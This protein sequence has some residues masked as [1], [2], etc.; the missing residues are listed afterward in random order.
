MIVHGYVLS[1]DIHGIVL[2]KGKP[3][4]GV[5]V[6]VAN[7]KDKFVVSDSLGCFFISDVQKEDSIVFSFVGFHDLRIPVC[8]LYNNNNQVIMTENSMNLNE[9]IVFRNKEISSDFSMKS[10]NQLE[11][12]ASPTSQADPLNAVLSTA[13]ST[14][15]LESAKPSLRGSSMGYTMV[16]INGVPV[17][18]P[19][20]GNLVNSS[21]ASSSSINATFVGSES[22]YASN[23]PIE[24]ENAASGSVNIQLN[25]DVKDRKNF[26]LSS[27]GTSF[28]VNRNFG[29]SFLESYLSYTDLYPFIKMNNTKDINH[30]RSYDAGIHY[31]KTLKKSAYSI[32][33]SYIY[34]NGNYPT[35]YLD[36]KTDYF[37]KSSFLN[38]IVNYEYYHAGVKLK[39]DFSYSHLKTNIKYKNIHM[40]EY[41]NYLYGAVSYSQFV[42]E[43]LQFKSGI[44]SIFSNFNTISYYSENRSD[45]EKGNMMQFTPYAS[46]KLILGNYSVLLGT[47]YSLAKDNKPAFNTNIS[48][49]YTNTHHKILLSAANLDMYNY[50]EN[51]LLRYSKMSCKQFCIEYDY[52]KSGLNGHFALYFK[53]ENGVNRM[54]PMVGDYKK[55]VFGIETSFEIQLLKN[56]SWSV[57]NTYLNT[58]YSFL[59]TIR[60]KGIRL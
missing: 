50:Y 33:S 1:S 44:N 27:V 6:Y 8:D 9:I 59:G 5:L 41:C 36:Q 31:H 45:M 32:F 4:C 52:K 10:Y 17:F 35:P 39:T 34:E 28:S 7:H 13:A 48:L 16:Y 23:S 22:I 15:T 53:G 25:T 38:N 49:K 19:T 43:K 56:I 20:K 12:F 40:N 30:Y 29:N 14:N 55:Y 3:M 2:T 47:K 37:N 60:G 54:P 42:N 51:T 18:Y 57:S 46:I 11:I 21:I 58:N 26:F 24:F